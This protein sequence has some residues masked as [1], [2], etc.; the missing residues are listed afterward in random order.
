GDG[1][2]FRKNYKLKYPIV[3]QVGSK[4]EE[5]GSYN[6]VEAM[7][8]IWDK[9]IR[10]HLVFAGMKREE[11]SN[12]LD[13]LEEKYRKWIVNIDDISDEEKWDLFAAGDIFSMV[14]KTDSFG[15]VYLEAWSNRIPVIGCNNE[16][17]K[18]VISN[19]K[20]GYLL[21]FDDIQGISRKIEYLLEDES[22]RKRMGE[23]GREKVE[24][25]YDW[26][27]NLDNLGKLYKELIV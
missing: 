17:I 3:F 24:R 10:A 11:F 14:S 12:Y 27:K 5:K 20:D 2:K 26:K 21:D 1:E 18:Q 6:L 19:D 8:N 15:I 16:A 4:N 7:K 13:S 9:N 23:N 25:K 22:E